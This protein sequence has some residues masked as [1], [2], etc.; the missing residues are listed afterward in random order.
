VAYDLN[1]REA[2]EAMTLFLAE[3]YERTSGDMATL[4]ADIQVEPDGITFDPAAWDDWLRCVAA[5]KDKG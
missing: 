1:E 5:V 4:M 2:F 3:F